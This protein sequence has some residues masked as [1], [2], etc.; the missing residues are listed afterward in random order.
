MISYDIQFYEQED[1]CPPG[2]TFVVTSAKHTYSQGETGVDFSE[3]DGQAIYEMHRVYDRQSTM[4]LD[5][6]RFSRNNGCNCVCTC[7]RPCEC[8]NNCLR[9]NSRGIPRCECGNDC[10]AHTEDKGLCGTYCKGQP[11]LG[12][13]IAHCF[14][15]YIAMTNGQSILYKNITTCTE[16]LHEM[17]KW[18]G[19][20]RTI[21]SANKS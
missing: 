4:Y 11:G 6:N 16:F 19:D 18:V 5:L 8:G 15:I 9:G 21:K 13:C 14:K 7:V 10:P 17:N 12:G 3:Y 2:H 1:A 20:G